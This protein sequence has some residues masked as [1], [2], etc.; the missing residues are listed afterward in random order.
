MGVIGGT[1]FKSYRYFGEIR[2]MCILWLC[3]YAVQSFLLLRGQKLLW[4]G[5]KAVFKKEHENTSSK[6]KQVTL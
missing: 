5:L 2:F 4:K 6:Y 1:S 3:K